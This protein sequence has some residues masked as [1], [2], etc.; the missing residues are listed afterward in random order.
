M[1]ERIRGS[2]NRVVGIKQTRK[3]IKEGKA[4]LVYLAK[5]VDAHLY[6][7]IE[8]LCQENHVDLCYVD[9]MKELGESCGIDIKAASAVLLKE[10]G[11]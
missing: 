8:E 1:L 9:T 6:N 2:K 5:D 4:Q 3:A 7:E 11:S 10:M